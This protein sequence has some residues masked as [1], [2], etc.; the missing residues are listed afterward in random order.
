[1]QNLSLSP[2]A[3]LADPGLQAWVTLRFAPEPLSL[4]DIVADVAARLIVPIA[5]RLRDIIRAIDEWVAADLVQMVGKPAMY[6]MAAGVRGRSNPP[7]SGPRSATH[8]TMRRTVRQRLWTAMRILK[9]FD[10]ITLHLAADVSEAQARRFVSTMVR[11]G[12]LRP[13]LPAGPMP[14]WVAGARPWGPVAPSLQYQLRDGRSVLI[15]TD[16]N[17]GTQIPLPS[18]WSRSL[19]HTTDGGVG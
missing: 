3:R 11:A 12:Y 8:W 2:A 15:L 17:D 7:S 18:R 13:A 10:L 6:A 9:R 16:R 5:G 1:M 19:D 14:A 4:A